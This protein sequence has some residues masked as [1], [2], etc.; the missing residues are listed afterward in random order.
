[1]TSDWRRKEWRQDPQTTFHCYVETACRCTNLGKSIRHTF[2][3]DPKITYQ[4]QSIFGIY[5]VRD[6]EC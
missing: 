4:P 1:M 5:P 6:M 2:Y 3:K